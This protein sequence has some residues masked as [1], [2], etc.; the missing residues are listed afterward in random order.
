MTESGFGSEDHI[1]RTLAAGSYALL[2]GIK[3]T[4]PS[5]ESLIK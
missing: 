1:I 3:T 5:I 2:F 4:T